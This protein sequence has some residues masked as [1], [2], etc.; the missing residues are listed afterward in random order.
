[1]L[2]IPTWA[3]RPLLCLWLGLFTNRVP[4]FSV[5][6]T[7]LPNLQE[8]RLSRS[9]KA[10]G[11]GYSSAGLSGAA[12][13]WAKEKQNVYLLLFSKGCPSSHLFQSGGLLV[14]SHGNRG[15]LVPEK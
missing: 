2:C 4:S 5:M 6:W 10:V 14:I 3:I 1:M 13:Q 9:H 7:F 15:D 11:S 12:G 8:K